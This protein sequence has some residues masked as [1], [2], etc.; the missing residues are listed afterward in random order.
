VAAS[1]GPKR[2]DAGAGSPASQGQLSKPAGSSL[3]ETLTPG[4]FLASELH[5]RLK[6]GHWVACDGWLAGSNAP[7]QEHTIKRAESNALNCFHGLVGWC[8]SILH[9]YINILITGEKFFHEYRNDH[10]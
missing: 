5:G 1:A 3:T 8:R 9:R 10:L 6:E 2:M 4:T 7:S